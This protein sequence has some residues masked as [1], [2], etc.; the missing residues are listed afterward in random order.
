MGYIASTVNEFFEKLDKMQRELTLFS[1]NLDN[2]SE[3]IPKLLEN[4]EQTVF[5]LADA[6]TGEENAVEQAA[7]KSLEKLKLTVEDW[8][9]KIEAERKG[10]EFIRKNEKFLVVMIF[11]AVKAGKS[12][13]GNFFAGKD[14]LSIPFDNPYKHIAKPVFEMEERGRSTG[15]LE[16]D[17]GGNV[18]FSEG[19]TDTT[20]AIQYFTLSGLRWVDSPGTGAVKKDG[21]SKNMTELVEE[22]LSYADMCIFLM[23]SSEPGLQDDMRYMQKLSKEGQEA[24]IVITKSDKQEE[25]IDE[26]DEIISITVPK[27]LE[28]RKLQEDDICKRVKE[29][30]PEIDA[31]RF[32]ALSTST[33]LARQALSENNEQ[34]YRDSNLDKLMK[35]LGDKVE[36]GAIERK[37]ANPKRLLN[38]FI[39]YIIDKLAEL[40]QDRQ[41]MEEAIGKFKSDMNSLSNLIVTNVKRAVK[42]DVMQQSYEWNRM[43]ERGEKV[44][45][46]SVS[47]SVA[48]ILKEKLNYEINT[49]M[50]R[51]IED[52]ESREFSAVKANI[53]ANQL[54]M[55]TATVTHTYTDYYEV[56]RKPRG[57]WENVCSVFGKKYYEE[58]S[59]TRTE[60]QIV[61]IGTNLDEFMNSLMPQVEE[62]AQHEASCS[63]NLLRDS[64]FKK[65][66]AFAKRMKQEIEKLRADLLSLKYEDK[67]C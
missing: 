59:K 15:D 10:K 12:T 22:Y 25:D 24:L 40:D 18:W 17:A 42:A 14:F 35:I 6:P 51:V 50:R 23:N 47:L 61:N 62:Y 33:L 55:K 16:K 21:D 4:F 57:I 30:Y 3:K 54:T 39:K 67:L 1:Q 44:D 26:N 52:Y 7:K 53:S 27:T 63:L 56:R 5:S 31:N 49:Q 60:K 36:T 65:R 41:E 48:N 9:K 43:V 28:T 2:R 8:R 34:K 66:E 45:N 46:S 64:Y 58:E 38:N 29:Q 32:R 11:G 20:G 19:V 37:E 13:L